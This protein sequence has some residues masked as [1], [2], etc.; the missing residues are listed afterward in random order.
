MDRDRSVLLI[1]EILLSDAGESQSNA[2]MDILMMLLF[3]AQERTFTQWQALLEQVKP[4]LR[5]V[6]VWRS[7][8]ESQAVVEAVLSS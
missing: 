8:H 2:E 3:G 4:P 5:I 7:K 1:D 6:H